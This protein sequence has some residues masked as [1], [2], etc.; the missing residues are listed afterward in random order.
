MKLTEVSGV[1]PAIERS[2]RDA[3]IGAVDDLAAA[4]A[5]ALFSRLKGLRALSIG[6]VQGWIDDARR[7]AGSPPPVE[8]S[9]RARE[10]FIITLSTPGPGVAIGTV[11]RSVR[12]DEEAGWA[13]WAAKA[14][15]DFMERTC[16]IERS[17]R[18]HPPAIRL[19]EPEPLDR[20]A[21]PG[22][23]QEL[24]GI[25]AATEQQLVDGGVASIGEL[26]AADAEELKASLG[27]GPRRSSDGVQRWIDLARAEAASP[28]LR[29]TFVVTIVA[30]PTGAVNRTTIRFVRVEEEEAGWAG[31]A[32]SEIVE[33]I[34]RACGLESMPRIDRSPA[35]EPTDDGNAFD[36]II[37]RHKERRLA[38]RL[39]LA[40]A[41]TGS[42]PAAAPSAV[43]VDPAPREIDDGDELD[44]D[45]L[46]ATAEEA[47][48]ARR[49]ARARRPL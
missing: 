30:S 34:A 37:V 40:R 42:A 8:A 38:R 31:W 33:F 22:D 21:H 43:Q 47:R 16:E 12:L 26:A 2:L 28:D 3:E 11:V 7:L 4:D 36:E 46:F 44:T 9:T 19:E 10:S 39:E 20:F 5:A 45:E 29:N 27:P 49:L 18:W 15:V 48:R 24:D 17:K 25:G 32:P 35:S 13:G 41:V 23:L 6:R 14:L 1:G